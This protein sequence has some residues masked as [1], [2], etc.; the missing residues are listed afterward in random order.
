[1]E[2]IS[3]AAS[4]RRANSQRAYASA[5][6]TR[7]CGF[8]NTLELMTPSIVEDRDRTDL[9]DFGSYAAVCRATLECCLWFF[10]LGVEDVGEER[11][12]D[13]LNLVHLHDCSY[14]TRLFRTLLNDED[15]ALKYEKARVELIERLEKGPTLAPLSVKQ[16]QH[17]LQG[18]DSRFTAQN[19]ILQAMGADVDQF[20]SWY[21]VLSSQA[22][23]LPF[24]FHRMLD[25]R[26]GDGVEREVDKAWVEGAM[27][28]TQSYL[29]RSASQ[30]LSL[31]PDIPDPRI[32]RR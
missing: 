6:F 4:G 18:I 29:A 17:I 32:A 28:F 25:D 13:R 26:R 9:W 2:V 7:L 22:H 8:A 11:W 15:E 14:R 24:S 3:I 1:M 10:Y 19:A 31:F 5:L 20:R 12:R 21:E 30:M 23:S 27:R 16:R